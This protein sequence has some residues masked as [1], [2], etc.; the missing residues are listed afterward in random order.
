MTMKKTIRIQKGQDYF[1]EVTSLAE[2]SQQSGWMVISETVE[3]VLPTGKELEQL[4]KD[5]N[6]GKIVVLPESK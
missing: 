5:L 4:N 1:L 3:I 6:D 2:Y